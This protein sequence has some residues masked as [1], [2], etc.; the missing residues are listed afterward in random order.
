MR[1]RPASVEDLP[2]VLAVERAAFGS[3]DEAELVRDLLD[4][5]TARPV[6][7]LLAEDDRGAI[8][9]ILLTSAVLEGEGD[10]VETMLLTPLAVVPG[11]QGKGV[12]GSLVRQALRDAAERGVGLVFVLGNPGY[13]ARCGFAPA[14]RHGL[15]APYPIDPA[16][17]DAWQVVETRPGLIGSVSGRLLPAEVLRRPDLWRE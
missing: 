16:M 6:I 10:V 3:N 17:P 1:I 12:G 2:A 5:P 14:S 13:Y 8:G 11:S 9:H 4:D 15:Q 7:D